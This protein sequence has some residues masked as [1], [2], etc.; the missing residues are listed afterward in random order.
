MFSLEQVLRAINQIFEAGIAITAFSLFIRSMTFRLADR[1]SRAFA[2]IMTCM[3][4][5]YSGE[6]IH[7]ALSASYETNFWLYFQWVGI[8]FLPAAFQHFSDA[9][10]DTTGRP[11]RGRRRF[12]LSMS[13]GISM[14]CVVLLAAGIFL[15]PGSVDNPY[16]T[17]T[18]FSLGFTLYYLISAVLST[19]GIWRAY[20]RTKL[21]AS[22]RRITYLLVGA[23]FLLVGAYPYMLLGSAFAQ[24][25]ST[26]F[27]FLVIF[28]NIGVF[29]CLLLLAYAVAFFGVPWPDRIVR[30][31]LLKWVLR[32]PIAVFVMLFLITVTEKT[33][34]YFNT[35]YQVAIP[36]ISVVSILLAEHSITVFFPYIER[37]LLNTGDGDHYYLL[38]RLSERLISSGDLKQFLEAILAGVCDQFQ[39]STGFVAAMD[40]GGW[41]IVVSTGDLDQYELGDMT[42]EVTQEILELETGRFFLW[43]DFWLIPLE[44]EKGDEMIGMIGVLRNEDVALDE[45]SSVGLNMLILRAE[46]ALEDRRLQRQ[47]L[48]SLEELSPKVDLLQRLRASIRFDQSEALKEIPEFEP[49]QDFSVWVKDAL[50]HYWGGP[51]LT[52]SPLIDLQIVQDSVEENEGVAANALRAILRDAMDQMKPAGERKFTPEWTLYN[53][54]DMK[55]LQGRKVREVARRLAVSEADLYRKQRVAIE[56]VA[57][58]I[59]EM[60]TKARES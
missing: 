12:V 15:G 35:P 2:V 39:V 57:N 32:G 22:R 46:L 60:E 1:V 40:N 37:W 19:V 8:I 7:G 26:L 59:I 13:Y 34:E 49:P 18:I 6:A 4:V 16:P 58:S 10:L 28:G 33:V 41:D 23:V 31:R 30:S 50:S 44:T 17:N 27:I 47:V 51:K 54:L 52:E 42:I 14:V 20:S 29:L 24:R 25:F 53:I 3:V 45:L 36:I 9:I 11:S 43:G 48:M 55:F 38:Q 21:R 56:T 5:I